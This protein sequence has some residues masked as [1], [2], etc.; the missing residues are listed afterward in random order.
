MI[1]GLV[2]ICR[3][4]SRDQAQ[5]IAPARLSRPNICEQD[6]RG[7]HHRRQVDGDEQRQD[8]EAF[9]AEDAKH[10]R[11]AE[12][13]EVGEG[14]DTPPTTPACE[15]RPKMRVVTRWPAVQATATA[16]K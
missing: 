10:E 13:H 5:R 12:Q 16:A 11:H 4:K 15:S 7:H 3:R 14:R 6:D 8:L 9:L 2:T 1:S